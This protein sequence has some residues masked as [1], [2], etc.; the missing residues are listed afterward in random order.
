MER[1]VSLLKRREDRIDFLK[2]L[3]TLLIE[4]YE[5]YSEDV[6]FRDAVEEIY[7]ILRSAVLEGKSELIDAYELSVLLRGSLDEKLPE[8]KAL[9][10]EILDRLG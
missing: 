6:L 1:L 8:P 5:L 3:I 10:K 4:D 2:D 9:L 7:S